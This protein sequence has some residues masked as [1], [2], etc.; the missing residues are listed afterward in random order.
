VQPAGHRLIEAVD[1]PDGRRQVL[2]EAVDVED[3]CPDCGVLSR[4]LHQRTRQRMRGF[5]GGGR[6]GSWRSWWSGAGWSAP[7]RSAPNR[8]APNRATITLNGSTLRGQGFC[9]GRGTTGNVGL[10]STEAESVIAVV[11]GPS[12]RRRPSGPREPHG[13]AWLSELLDSGNVDALS[14]DAHEHTA[15]VMDLSGTQRG[16]TR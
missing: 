11:D 5:P 14:A 10:V 13:C 9:I 6:P 1:I 4:R 16:G 15:N 8:S 3:G 2:V 7:N 12:T